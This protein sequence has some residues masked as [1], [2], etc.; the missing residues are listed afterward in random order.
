MSVA[1]DSDVTM[2]LWHCVKNVDTVYET[3]FQMALAILGSRLGMRLLS[4]ML[5]HPNWDLLP[6]HIHRYNTAHDFLQR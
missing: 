2:S 6:T 4:M 3:I 1:C 5:I